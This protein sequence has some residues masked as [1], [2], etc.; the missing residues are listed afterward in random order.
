MPGI[1]CC[2]LFYLSYSR[3]GGA[4]CGRDTGCFFCIYLVG[5]SP[6]APKRGMYYGMPGW[7]WERAGD[8]LPYWFTDWAGWVCA[9]LWGKRVRQDNGDKAGQRLDPPFCGGR[10]FIG[11]GSSKWDG[12][13]RYGNVPSGGAGRLRVP[14]P[15][16]TV[17]QYWFW[18]RDYVRAR[19]CGSCPGKDKRAGWNH[20]FGVKD[21]KAPWEEYFLHVRRGKT[22][23][24]FCKR[25]C[26]EPVCVC[27]GW[28]DS[29]SRCGGGQ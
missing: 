9:S 24:C 2:I 21:W 10:R 22:E 19:K 13:C 17:F 12:G 16:V 14:E 4:V 26:H 1:R 23:P 29:Q 5:R 15:Q 20:G 7:V 8:A 25:L 11:Q 27:T 18:Q 3:I 28:A 6:P